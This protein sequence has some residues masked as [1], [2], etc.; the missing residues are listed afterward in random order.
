MIRAHEGV[1]LGRIVDVLM[2]GILP[3]HENGEGVIMQEMKIHAD[4]ADLVAIVAI[5]RVC[6]RS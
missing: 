3:I 5:R 1:G 2:P 6:N 4:T